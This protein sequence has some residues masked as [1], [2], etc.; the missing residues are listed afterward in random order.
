MNIC[1][2]LPSNQSFYK[3]IIGYGVSVG[4]HRV[5]RRWKGVMGQQNSYMTL[6]GV[7]STMHIVHPN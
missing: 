4:E 1:W 3:E 7:H 6:I 2:Q 5:A